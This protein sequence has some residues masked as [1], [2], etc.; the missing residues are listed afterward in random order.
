MTIDIPTL[1]QR[2]LTGPES[3][4]TA[5]AGLSTAQLA[6][7]AN[8]GRWSIQQVVCPSLRLRDRLC[9]S[10]QTRPGEKRPTMFSGDPDQ[11]AARLAYTQRTVE[12]ELQLIT[13]LR[14]SVATITAAD[15]HW[16]LGT[17]RRPQR[18]G[19]TDVAHTG[20]A[21]H[22]AH[23]ASPAI[24]PGEAGDARFCELKEW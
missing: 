10:H 3:L 14:R 16:R 15:G 2:Y 9:R 24:H 5:C 20:R 4:R 21:S 7:P 1:I 19:A 8:P 17:R 22:R 18:C 13:A 23:P 6:T 12:D 11:F